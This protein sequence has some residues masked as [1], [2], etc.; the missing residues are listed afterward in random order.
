MKNVPDPRPIY[1]INCSYSDDFCKGLDG[2]ETVSTVLHEFPQSSCELLFRTEATPDGHSI[3][4]FPA[5]KSGICNCVHM[6]DGV[7]CQLKPCRFAVLMCDSDGKFLSDVNK[8]LFSKIADGFPIVESGVESYDCKNY[9]SILN[10]VYKEKMDSIVQ[11]ELSEGMISRVFQK[12]HCIHA[13]G[14]VPKPDGGLRPIT[15]CSRPVG[16]AVNHRCDG[17]VQKFHYMS[18]DS[19][20]EILQPNEF[21]AIIDI[22]S[23]YRAVSIHP[24]HRTYVG[25]RWFID[26]EECFFVD[27]RL[28]FGLKSGPCHFN[29]ISCFIADFI[30]VH[31]QIR[32]VQYLDDF[33]CIGSDF[34]SCKQAQDIIIAILRYVGFYISWNKVSSPARIVTFLGIIID[35]T[36]MELRLPV[37]KLEKMYSLL[38]G[39]DSAT[40]I[41]KKDLEVL[42]GVLAHCATIIKGGRVFC[43][44][45][46]DLFKVMVQKNLS[47]ITIPISARKDIHWWFQFSHVFNGRSAIS[48]P[49]YA[50]VMVSDSS[51]KGFG[52]YLGA[53]WIAGTWPDIPPLTI[54]TSCHHIGSAPTT[55]ID[56]DNINILELW[57]I[58]LGLH[59]WYRRF[60]GTTVCLL[61]DNTQVLGML[62]KGS[63]VNMTCMDW[64]REIFWVCF[65]N[66]IQLQPE[67]ISTIDNTLADALSRL[68]Y[69]KDCDYDTAELMSNLCCANDL[70]NLTSRLDSVGCSAPCI[71]S[72]FSVKND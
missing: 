38:C 56:Y 19:V 1:D 59:R 60:R 5:C 24:T 52:V 3:D 7:Q 10:D 54:K 26:N 2:D 72:K 46:Y 47:R 21:M 68:A 35:S 9:L 71:D 14:A 69:H 4:I 53:D 17:I 66:N 28:C 55:E 31:Y 39:V 15:D 22:K 34:Q 25:F 29:S 42:C 57:P 49:P 51:M 6:L 48:N 12:P 11:K 50:E 44:R 61:T 41:S 43:R 16:M 36:K 40:V 32:V 67:Y 8:S 58:L 70:L 13:L 27:N 65:I 62:K 63:S 64:V 37:E 33:I 30:R 18:V 20:T 23:A 45:L